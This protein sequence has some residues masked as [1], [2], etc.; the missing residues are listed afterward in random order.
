MNKKWIGGILGVL[1]LGSIG[2]A[3]LNGG[4]KNSLVYETTTMTG[5]T[6][7]T[8]VSVVGSVKA[9]KETNLAF[10]R[11]GTVE[12]VSA[13][14]GMRVSSGQLLASLDNTTLRAEV[15]RSRATL[16]IE[17]S[18]LQ[19][20]RE[21]AAPVDQAVL[22]T[23]VRNAQLAL[24]ALRVTVD[25]TQERSQK[26]VEEARLAYENAQ[27]VY[28]ASRST[29]TGVNTADIRALEVA[30]V[31]AKASLEATQATNAQAIQSAEV[32]LS[33]AK[34]EL[35]ANSPIANKNLE[36]AQERSFYD[37][38]AYQE[39]VD[40]SLRTI[41]DIITVEDY[42]NGQNSAYR[43]LLGVGL[44][45]SYNNTLTQYYDL[46]NT[47]N[48]N[49]DVFA[50]TNTAI[51][52]QEILRRLDTLR[53]LLQ[54]SYTAL[55][56]TNTMLENSITSSTFPQSQLEAY[57]SAVLSQRTAVS[58]AISGLATIR[59]NVE[60][61]ELQKTSS[62]TTYTNRVASAEAA[63]TSA[64]AQSVASETQAR[65]AVTSAEENL[66][67][68][69]AGVSAKDV[70]IQ[71]LQNAAEEAAKRLSSAEA[72]LQEQ[73]ASSNK[74]ISDLQAQLRSAE[75]QRTA[76]AGPARAEDIAIQESRVRQAQT[77]LQ[78]AENNLEDAY[79]RSPKSGI[80]S[81]VAISEGEQAAPSAGVISLISED[82]SVIEANI[83]ENEIAEVQP[84]QLV[85]ITFD[86]FDS[87]IVYSGRVTFI[88][89][90][91]TAL[92]GVIYYR[93]EISFDPLEHPE[94]T[95][96]PGFSANLDIVTEEIF[97][98]AIPIQA[99][100]DAGDKGKKVEVLVG[101]GAT[102]TAEGRFVEVGMIGDE[103]IEVLSGLTQADAVVLSAT[104][105]ET[106]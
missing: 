104:E 14:E 57:R 58:N 10:A 16:D 59:Q 26:E 49:R 53:T 89:P 36:D 71:R 85:D 2:F 17:Q 8:V 79:I 24:D 95:V 41:N 39:Q 15:D 42:N 21:G 67:K 90:A 12:S 60:N 87:D 98:D 32:A 63:L 33:N 97:T 18:T 69:T 45:N 83:A 102:A 91:Q 88:D 35:E 105:P 54:K 93:T 19:K 65:A 5:T 28:L 96:R 20:L 62:D 92:D 13:K 7:R 22:N 77:A 56:T 75:V 11:S 25:A 48:T 55:S 72:R 51:S 80:I 6:V 94:N 64:K 61:L 73:I 52:Y 86:A 47:F 37:A 30:V 23:T 106:E 31:S 38:T 84:G 43:S 4:Q 76:Q 78:V 66:R 100:K 3:A 70:D 101:S 68:A 46:R 40:K 34:R 44:V 74:S 27:Q 9:E 81:E 99:V 82:F 29:T 103:Y 50:I 1:I